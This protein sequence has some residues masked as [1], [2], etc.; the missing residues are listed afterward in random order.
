MWRTILAVRPP[1][2]K[3][4]APML[5]EAPA[6][7]RLK[8]AVGTK[9]ASNPMD[10]SRSALWP[11][12]KPSQKRSTTTI[13]RVTRSSPKRTLQRVAP[14]FPKPPPL[15][16]PPPSPPSPP[17]PP[18]LR[19]ALSLWSA[20]TSRQ[21]SASISLIIPDLSLLGRRVDHSC[22]HQ[23]WGQVRV[24]WVGRELFQ[25]ASHLSQ[26]DGEGHLG[27]QLPVLLAPSHACTPTS[28]AGTPS[29]TGSHFLSARGDHPSS[30]DVGEFCALGIIVKAHIGHV[31][32]ELG[33]QRVGHAEVLFHIFARVHDR[34]TLRRQGVFEQ[35]RRVRWQRDEV[36]RRDL[37]TLRLSGLTAVAL[38]S[39]V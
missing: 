32:N 13:S 19:H 24:V 29:D 36:Q 18:P 33:Q 31:F 16:P 6:P 5:T 8:E 7:T 10:T 34:R 9:S 15:P 28:H 14:K 2:W 27:G 22:I 37:V 21:T 35:S 17:P 26:G 4:R 11:R 23:D 20:W 1:R 38:A 30:S 25:S 39:P 12:R 3:G